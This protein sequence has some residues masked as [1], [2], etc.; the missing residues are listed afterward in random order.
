M[1]DLRNALAGIQD[2]FDSIMPPTRMA[3]LWR[4]YQVY[5]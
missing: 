1:F 4:D 2:K 3:N 5:L